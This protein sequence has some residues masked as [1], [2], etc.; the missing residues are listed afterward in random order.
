MARWL[1]GRGELSADLGCGRFFLT[2]D[3]GDHD[4]STGEVS[5]KERPLHAPFELRFRVQ[6]LGPETEKPIWVQILGAHLYFKPGEVT[7][8][9]HRKL[10]PQA[11]TRALAG[12]LPHDEHAVIV[13][14]TSAAVEVRV[15]DR[16]PIVFAFAPGS[17]TGRMAIGF[18]G[19]RGYRSRLAFGDVS[20]RQ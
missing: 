7:L 10:S 11:G 16:P 1:V 9:P 12:Y 15:D 14:Q 18:N 13:R 17:E 5:W 2:T 6:R 3:A 20:L 4:E 19:A 8:W